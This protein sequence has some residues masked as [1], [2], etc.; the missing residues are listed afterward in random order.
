MEIK[1]ISLQTLWCTTF[2][3]SK[4]EICSVESW[5]NEK[6]TWWYYFFYQSTINYRVL[7]Y[8]VDDFCWEG[9]EQFQ[10]TIIGKIKETFIQEEILHSRRNYSCINIYQNLYND[11]LSETEINS[12]KLEKQ[13][14]LNK[15]EAWQL[16][17]LA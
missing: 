15:E 11:K 10:S 14:Q 9:S 12:G 8:H 5:G 16:H 7:C 2:L 17:G 1:Y 4:F 3:I 13:A 6:K